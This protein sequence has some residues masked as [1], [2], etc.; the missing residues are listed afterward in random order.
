MDSLPDYIYFDHAATTPVLPDVVQEMSTCL[1][2]FY[3]NPSEP[4]LP[5]REANKILQ[6]SKQTIGKA[7][8]CSPEQIIFT[9]GATESN[10]LAIFGAAEAYQKKGNHII[11]SSIEHPSAIMPLRRLQRKGFEVTYIPVDANGIIDPE[12]VRRAIRPETVMASIMHA[13]NIFG[14]IEPIAQIGNILK[15]RGIVFHSDAA[16]TFCNIDI[17]AEK[18]NVDLLSISGHKFYGPKGI[19]ALYIRKGTRIMPQLFGGGQQ[20]GVRPG[21]ENI[22]AVAGLA[23]ACQIGQRNLVANIIKV[24]VLREYLIEKALNSIEDIRLCGHPVKRL[25][26]NCCFILKNISG[27]AMVAEL[28]KASIAVSGSSACAASSIK[29]ASAITSL[30]ISC[31]EA[32]GSVRISLGFENTLKEI[33]YFLKVFPP[34][35]NKLR[36]GL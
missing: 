9:S 36:S 19:G 29:P 11:T 16:Q 7:M 25:P 8:N 5:G 27:K 26:G 10:N 14:T 22:P 4:H 3:G 30:G 6:N 31:D 13:N 34:I 21:T 20:R 35:V 23:K 24:T 17:D 28:D 33:D 32:V 18:L 2:K 15:E 1:N 12:E